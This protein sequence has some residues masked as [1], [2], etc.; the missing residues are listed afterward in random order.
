MAVQTSCSTLSRSLAAMKRRLL[1]APLDPPTGLV[2]RSWYLIVCFFVALP[3]QFPVFPFEWSGE[4]RHPGYRSQTTWRR[5]AQ[6]KSRRVGFVLPAKRACFEPGSLPT[7]QGLRPS[8]KSKTLSALVRANTE[9][10]FAVL[11]GRALSRANWTR[12]NSNLEA[13]F[14][15]QVDVKLSSRCRVRPIA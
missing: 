14:T 5:L 11:I 7:H 15:L 12:Q 10:I 13:K 1:Y 2:G 8:A 6:L 9:A 4:P 3:P